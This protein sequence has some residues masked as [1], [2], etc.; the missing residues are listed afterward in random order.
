MTEV[1]STLFI[2]HWENTHSLLRNVTLGISYTF[3]LQYNGNMISDQGVRSNRG[4]TQATESYYQTVRHVAYLSF[5]ELRC[6][7]EQCS[8]HRLVIL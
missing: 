3:D 6:L 7:S 2:I 8:K 5:R 4:H 1:C